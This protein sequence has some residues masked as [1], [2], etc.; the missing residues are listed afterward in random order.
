MLTFLANSILNVSLN[1][2]KCSNY[3]KILLNNNFD[4]MVYP[5]S[6]LKMRERWQ[7]GGSPPI[8][9]LTADVYKTHRFSQ[10]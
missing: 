2:Y 6:D 8:L 9:I 10:P 5:A 3:Y 7:K 4:S 1:P